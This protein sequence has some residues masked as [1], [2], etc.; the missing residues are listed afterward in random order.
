MTNPWHS[1]V[2]QVGAKGPKVAHREPSF[3]SARPM[4]MKTGGFPGVPGKTGPNRNTWKTAKK[5][6]THTTDEGL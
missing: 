5:V 3:A 2:S 6:K 4:P 1:D